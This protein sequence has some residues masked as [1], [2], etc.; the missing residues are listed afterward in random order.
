MPVE[1]EC[2]GI[3]FHVQWKKKPGT[4]TRQDDTSI[5]LWDPDD[6]TLDWPTFKSYVCQNLGVAD[7]LTVAYMDSEGDE[8]P[9]ESEC[10]F[11]EALKFARQQSYK[12]VITVLKVDRQEAGNSSTP[13]SK[14]S[15]NVSQDK[16]KSLLMSCT[17]QK[18]K[19]ASK[20]T[21]KS[22][23]SGKNGHSSTSEDRRSKESKAR[24]SVDNRDS[25]NMDQ[26]ELLL[27]V[28]EKLKKMNL[29]QTDAPPPWFRRYMQKMKSDIVTE[30]TNN[31]LH[32]IQR[33]VP[34][35]RDYN[36]PRSNSWVLNK[37]KKKKKL[38]DE[39]SSD[40]ALGCESRDHKLL[41]KIEKLH[42]REKKLEKLDS[43]LEKL[44]N[45]T[46]R[47]MEK[48]SQCKARCERLPERKICPVKRR[49]GDLHFGTY[50]MDA[51]LLNDGPASEI[52]IFP[53]HNFTKV[54]EI[55][56]AGTLPWTDKTE[57][58]Q[59]WGT[60]GLE[61]EETVVKCPILQPGEQGTISVRFRAP[62]FPGKFKSYWHFYHMG[63]RFGHW[64]GCAVV[65]KDM[66]ELPGHLN[67]EVIYE[68]NGQN[69]LSLDSGIKNKSDVIN[70]L[71]YCKTEC[72]LKS[73]L[74]PAHRREEYES[75]FESDNL[76]VISGPGSESSDSDDE[77]FVVIP[78]PACFV[79][80]VPLGQAETVP[81]LVKSELK[82]SKYVNEQGVK[83]N[84]LIDLISSSTV[85]EP[86]QYEDKPLE[87]VYAVDPSGCCIA[88]KDSSESGVQN[89]ERVQSQ[90]SSS[91]AEANWSETPHR[92][93]SEPKNH[94]Q[95]N[96][97]H[98]ATHSHATGT[99]Q[100]ATDDVHSN[101]HGN[102][103]STSNTNKH[104]PSGSMGQDPLT[105]VI[106]I[107]PETLVAGAVNVASTAY[108]TARAVI[109][110]LQH[111]TRQIGEGQEWQ[112]ND[113]PENVVQPDSTT[114]GNLEL[115]QEMGF[116]NRI[117]NVLLLQ[118][119]DNDLTK[120]VAELLSLE[121]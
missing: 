48:R 118:R 15:E 46:K 76:S 22:N 21:H 26:G 116:S 106:H 93:E 45:K 29:E 35:Q 3:T 39:E 88:V 28:L 81:V 108:S 44:E 32:E 64:I 110:N 66:K 85:N 33:V 47:M 57:L 1:M 99:E 119:Y 87:K 79:C 40:G 120:V 60:S 78:M 8:L 71:P 100:A 77:N 7:N 70:K 89:S 31:I 104:S 25:P 65:V 23:S 72:K 4:V 101:S 2:P 91:I 5:G 111:R 43:K 38:S 94:K 67:K 112:W 55:M 82:E 114:T 13:T 62:A 97:S 42:K 68:P 113:L 10:E 105:N 54:W 73:S 16:A 83:G 86:E 69:D 115:L 19:T 14:V 109:N 49:S 24:S 98:S 41:K 36:A 103:S 107:L 96:N 17:K 52:T 92:C 9:I 95:E 63:D 18:S 56:N 11:R 121:G 12:G 80:D 20:S 27:K 50:L 53:G 37:N 30:V 61:P 34:M 102:N 74:P 84:V 6:S 51:I 90:S 58:R 59:A 75:D 117:L